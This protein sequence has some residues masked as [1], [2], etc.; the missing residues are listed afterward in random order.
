MD[1]TQAGTA[2]VVC[3][4]SPLLCLLLSALINHTHI[5]S[6][7]KG[8]LNS[9]QSVRSTRKPTNQ[10]KKEASKVKKWQNVKKEE[11]EARVRRSVRV[12]V[13]ERE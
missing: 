4:T 9:T 6:P 11:V 5:S 3:T 7:E 10:L 8:K 12:G 2:H 13:R 1:L